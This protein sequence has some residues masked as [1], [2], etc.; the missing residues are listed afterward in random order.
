MTIYD[1]IAEALNLPPIETD[2]DYLSHIVPFRSVI[3]SP[4]NK[5][6]KMCDGQRRLIGSKMKGK[7]AWN[8]G[9][10]NLSSADNGKKSAK[11]QS[12]TVTGR[13]MMKD[14][15]TGRRYWVYPNS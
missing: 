2:T 10:P 13:R 9:L 12:D 8:K 3:P 14:E 11:K 1:P 15:T 6:V 5:G 4:V 7:P